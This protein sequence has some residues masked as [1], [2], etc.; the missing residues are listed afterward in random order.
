M[1]ALKLL[2]PNCDKQIKKGDNFCY[3][4]GVKVPSGRDLCVQCRFPVE[5]IDSF[6]RNCGQRLINIRVTENN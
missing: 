6:C 4:C 3:A 5:K 1:W 2:C